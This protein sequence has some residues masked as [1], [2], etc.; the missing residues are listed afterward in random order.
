MSDM[1]YNERE[2]LET[3]QALVPEYQRVLVSEGFSCSSEAEF[4]AIG[5]KL[6]GEDH[7]PGFLLRTGVPPSPETKGKNLLQAVKDEVHSLLCTTS[8]KYSSERQD[9]ISS[10][11]QLVT[12]I[13]TALAA[14]F[15]V[16]VGIFVGA[17]TLVLMCA[18]KMTT[19]A[20]CAIHAPK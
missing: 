18:L 9:G 13:A 19:S 6:T 11:K 1:A 5:M 14:Q 8:K 15:N 7:S 4:D 17:V 20:W 16:G 10:I 2:F 3:I 12:I